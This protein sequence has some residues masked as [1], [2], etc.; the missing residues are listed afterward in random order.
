MKEEFKSF[1][2]NLR[3]FRTMHF[4]IMVFFG[5]F[6]KYQFN[7][8]Y[9]VSCLFVGMI[10][11]FFAWQFNV[12]INDIYDVEIDKVSNV[13]RPLSKDLISIRTY[14]IIAII[15][16]CLSILF[17][18]VLG[19]LSM[20]F[21]C[22]YLASGYAYSAPV[23]RL[24]KYIFGT[25]F[26]GLWSAMAFYFAFF[27]WNFNIRY[28]VIIIGILIFIALS[29]G[30]VVKDYKDYEGDKAND[31]QTI[32][33][34]FGLKKGSWICSA[35]M[36][37]TFIIP[38]FLVFSV[39]DLSIII[40]IAVS[41]VLL[42]NWKQNTRKVEVTFLLYFVEIAYVFMRYIGILTVLI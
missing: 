1:I 28:D 34:K 18:L 24:R 7:L 31:V 25:L 11:I 4:I 12:I 37:I 26:I 14:K 35:F 32:F 41:A 8:F 30:T 17:G 21:L 15:F 5:I 27:S 9:F 19:P 13:D 36:F 20:V 3:P 23:L 22:V 10:S 16:L 40:S 38:F 2:K 29:L 33:T 39:T 42:F 6:F